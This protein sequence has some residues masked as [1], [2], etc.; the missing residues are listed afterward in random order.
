MNTYRM[1]HVGPIGGSVR[2]CAIVYSAIAGPEEQV[3]SPIDC[4]L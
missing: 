3:N 1:G 2:D 4:V